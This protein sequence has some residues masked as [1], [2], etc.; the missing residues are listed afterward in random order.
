MVKEFIYW[1]FDENNGDIYEGEFV[2][3]II[4]GKG[5]YQ[6]NYGTK[7]IGDFL[8]GVRHGKGKE[9]IDGSYFEGEFKEGKKDGEGTY[10][11]AEGNW[12][13]GIYREGKEN[14]QGKIIYNNEDTLE[15]TWLNGLKQV[16]FI[17]KDYN[18]NSFIRKNDKDQL[19]EEKNDGLFSSIYRKLKSFI[20]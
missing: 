9:K 12:F 16:E 19:I 6:Y 10:L 8:H 15:R 2:N 5:V 20:H 11:D 18:G 1:Y 13:K 17:F 4:E 14:G 3:D 7:Y